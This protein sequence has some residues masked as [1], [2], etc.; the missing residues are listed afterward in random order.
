MLW[1]ARDAQPNTTVV[2]EPMTLMRFPTAVRHDVEVEAWIAAR[3]DDLRRNRPA[4]V[5]VNVF[6]ATATTS[7]N[8]S[9]DTEPFLASRHWRKH[10][11]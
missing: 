4:C 11:C 2:V 9:G 7:S 10:S 6:V 5:V 3:R 8:A 1:R